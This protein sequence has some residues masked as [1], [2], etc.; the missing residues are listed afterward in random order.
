MILLNEQPIRRWGREHLEAA[1]LGAATHLFGADVCAETSRSDL[2]QAV[3][4]DHSHW[5]KYFGFIPTEQS[6]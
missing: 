6:G 2:D 1:R 5:S 3:E 4:G